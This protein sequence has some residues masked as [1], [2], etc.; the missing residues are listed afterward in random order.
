MAGARSILSAPSDG[1]TDCRQ[2]EMRTC[3]SFRVLRRLYSPALAGRESSVAICAT[4]VERFRTWP[5]AVPVAVFGN[6]HPNEHL[7]QKSRLIGTAQFCTN[8]SKA[9]RGLEICQ[10]PEN[11]R[12]S[13]LSAAGF[14]CIPRENHPVSVVQCGTETGPKMTQNRPSGWSLHW[15]LTG[16]YRPSVCDWRG[17]RLAQREIGQSES[18]PVP[19]DVLNRA[20]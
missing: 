2:I 3:A 18:M 10:M 8:W 1:G 13:G 11:K 6:I 9:L 15:V 16:R 20:S 19:H 7:R 17:Y 14:H 5:H 4:R 12:Q